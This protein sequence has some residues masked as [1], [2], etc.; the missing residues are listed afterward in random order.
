MKL[1]PQHKCGRC[2]RNIQRNLFHCKTILM[3][4]CD[5][6][7]CAFICWPAHAEIHDAEWRHLTDEAK[8]KI[9]Q[10]RHDNG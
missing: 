10:E 8:E 1:I 9:I 3:N 2:G 7:Y 5:G 6:Y 4:G